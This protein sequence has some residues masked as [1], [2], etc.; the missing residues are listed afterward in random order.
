M[1]LQNRAVVV[2]MEEGFKNDTV[3][4][5]GGDQN[6]QKK[7]FMRFTTMPNINDYPGPLGGRPRRGASAPAARPHHAGLTNVGVVA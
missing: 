4:L 7:G 1:L 5:R 6:R 2:G 3:V